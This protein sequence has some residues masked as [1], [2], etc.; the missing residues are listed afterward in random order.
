MLNLRSKETLTA[1]AD[2]CR[3]RRDISVESSREVRLIAPTIGIISINL[4]S[5][6]PRCIA[7]IVADI[8]SLSLLSP[9]ARAFS[10]RRSPSSSKL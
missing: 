1:L 2:S 8:R 3:A 4:R 7:V 6:H 5:H 10:K 9:I